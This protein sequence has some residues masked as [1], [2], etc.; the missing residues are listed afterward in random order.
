M[1]DLSSKIDTSNGISCEHFKL[2]KEYLNNF[3][4]ELEKNNKV[5]DTLKKEIENKNSIIDEKED[6]IENFN[7]VS[8]IYSLNKQI[9]EK[10]NIIKK[11]EYQLENTKK[12]LTQLQQDIKLSSVSESKKNDNVTD[13]IPID[14]HQDAGVPIQSITEERADEK[15][16]NHT[17]I[18]TETPVDQTENNKIEDNPSEKKKK[19]EFTE[20]KIKNKTFYICESK[21][22]KKLKSGKISKKSIGTYID[23]NDFKFD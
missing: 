11:L 4:S 10:D 21:I 19:R 6:E 7:K 1:S 16:Q 9:T 3:I 14:C 15:H 13:N 17:D 5:I 12:K 20:V 18:T 2:A 23:E 22:Y 8:I